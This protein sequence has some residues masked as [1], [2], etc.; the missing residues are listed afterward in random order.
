MR[1]K[2]DKVYSDQRDCCEGGTIYSLYAHLIPFLF[3]F[4]ERK[5]RTRKEDRCGR[6]CRQYKVHNQ[7]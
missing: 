1:F 3:I 6:H 2:K 4:E 5:G 7:E